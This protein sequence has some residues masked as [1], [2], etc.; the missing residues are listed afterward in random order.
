MA[1]AVI[2]NDN[3]PEDLSLREKLIGL[4]LVIALVLSLAFI[5]KG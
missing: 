1:E 3:D 5:V 4:A 2:I